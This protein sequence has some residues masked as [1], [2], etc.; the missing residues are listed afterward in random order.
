MPPYMLVLN[1]PSMFYWQCFIDGCGDNVDDLKDT[2]SSH[3]TFCEDTFIPVKKVVGC[4]PNNK[5][6]LN[7]DVKAA[8]NRKKI[9]VCQVT[10]KQ[11]KRQLE[12]LGPRLLKLKV[13]I[14]KK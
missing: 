2:M 7:I 12:K 11:K 13:S 8:I 14:G 6:W 1:V 9:S 4:F 5:S 10:S 3:V